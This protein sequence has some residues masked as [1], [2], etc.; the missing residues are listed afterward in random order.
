MLLSLIPSSL[1]GDGLA[2]LVSEIGLGIIMG[3]GALW[4][5]VVI[6]TASG[7]VRKD[8]KPPACHCW[9]DSA[10]ICPQHGE[11]Q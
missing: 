10:D 1:L 8:A 3:A 4:T 7:A 2:Q 6:F 11:I 9:C 5:I